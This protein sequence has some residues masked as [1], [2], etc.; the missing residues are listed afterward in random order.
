MSG[1]PART[2]SP[3]FTVR[4]LPFAMRY[5]FASPALLG[6][7]EDLALA[8]RVLAEGHRAVDLG[9][10][11]VVLGL[12][13]LEELG[14]ARQTARDVLRLRGL[15]RHLREDLARVHVLAVRT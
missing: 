5:S 10:D 1:S 12:A 4:A 14:H 9:D 2:K 11:G 6:G 15:A 8:L 13:G 3:S 7:H